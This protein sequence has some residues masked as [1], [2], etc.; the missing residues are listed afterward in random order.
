M[1]VA[2][3]ALFVAMGGTGYA[4]LNLPRNS[5]G[6]KQLKKNAVRSSKVKDRSLRARDFARGQ[7]P[8]GK[9]GVPGPPGDRGATGRRGAP[10]SP[11]VPGEPGSARAYMTVDDTTESNTTVPPSLAKN[12]SAANVERAA[13]GMYCITPPSGIDAAEVTPVASVQVGGNNTGQ[14]VQTIG[15]TQGALSG[16]GA[17]RWLVET[18]FYD[19]GGA[20]SGTDDGDVVQ[21]SDAGFSLLVP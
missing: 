21:R 5:V 20:I 6:A 10:G 13:S 14:F 2:L 19:D 3:L 4:A 9:Q 1:V 17:D 8:R 12:M 11:G 15:V 18:Y 16:C 7:L